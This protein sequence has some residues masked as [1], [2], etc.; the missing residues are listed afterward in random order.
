MEN[1]KW[2][3]N[4]LCLAFLS[5]S[6]IIASLFLT[7][8]AEEPSPPPPLRL[9]FRESLLRGMVLQVH[10]VSPQKVTCHL[11]VKASDGKSKTHSFSLEPYKN[12]ELGVME[13]DCYLLEGDRGNITVDGY[14]KKVCFAIYSNSYRDWI[15]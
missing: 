10:N 9:S 15:E 3:I 11:F 13:M 1:G 12:T 5:L 2:K 8:C 14:R 4:K 7:G 6:A